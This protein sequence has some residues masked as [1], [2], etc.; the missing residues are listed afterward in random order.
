MKSSKKQPKKSPPPDVYVAIVYTFFVADR[1]ASDE[2]LIDDAHEAIRD[3]MDANSVAAMYT[4]ID[5]SKIYNL[6]PVVIDEYGDSR[7]ARR[8]SINLPSLQ[9]VYPWDYRKSARATDEKSAF[10]LLVQRNKYDA[11]DSHVDVQAVA[12]DL[13]TCH[14][15]MKKFGYKRVKAK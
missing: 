12:T 14:R 11:D 13:E 15:L 5:A 4:K 9:D 8:V 3:E 7:D 10:T 1:K 6:E 2:K